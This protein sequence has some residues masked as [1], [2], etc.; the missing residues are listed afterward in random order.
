MENS[1][2]IDPDGC[3][4]VIEV[5]RDSPAWKAGLRPNTFISLVEG[6]RVSTPEQFYQALSNKLGSVRLR[7]STPQGSD[8][9]VRIVSPLDVE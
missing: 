4:A 9:V 1:R 2:N 8:S 7:L 5:D 6:K 3:V